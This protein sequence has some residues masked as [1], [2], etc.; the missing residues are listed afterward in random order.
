MQQ[1]QKF[2]PELDAHI[3]SHLGG[4]MSDYMEGK[5]KSSFYDVKVILDDI[6]QSGN[7]NDG[8]DRVDYVINRFVEGLRA[9]KENADNKKPVGD[10]GFF[11]PRR[12]HTDNVKKIISSRIALAIY[13]PDSDSLDDITKSY[14]W[15]QSLIS[16]L[17]RLFK[18]QEFEKI[19]RQEK[20]KISRLAEHRELWESLKTRPL[21]TE[22]TEPT[23]MPVEVSPIE[24]LQPFFNFLSSNKEVLEERAGLEGAEWLTDDK[25]YKFTRGAIYTDGRMDLCKQ[26]VGPPHIESLMTSL[27]HNDKV[28][29]FLLGNNIIGQNGGKAVKTF[30]TSEH[31]PHIRTWYLAGNDLDAVG[32][33]DVVDGLCDDTDV[34]ELWLKRNPIKADGAV[35]IRRLLEKNNTLNTLDLHNTG[36]LDEGF[37]HVCEGLKS[38]RSVKY[39]YFE[40]NGITN[41]DP[42]VSYFEHMIESNECGITS[43]WIGMNR[44]SDD[45][46]I[47]LCNAIKNY[48]WLERLCIGS[49][50]ISHR[51]CQTIY[52]AFKNH[53]TI[54]LLDM[55]LYKSTADMGEI[56]N[57]IGDEGARWI[58]K[59]ISENT[60][61][62]FVSVLHNDISNDGIADILLGLQHNE[63]LL[64][65]ETKQYFVGIEQDVQKKINDI[66]NVN[67][68]RKGITSPRSY[69]RF[70]KH[71]DDIVN[72]DSIYRNNDKAAGPTCSLKKQKWLESKKHA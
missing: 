65:L 8:D 56:T 62:E 11:A 5:R 15:Y 63:N 12:P 41:I 34:K 57:R 53:P 4:I 69:L 16:R 40:A 9:E 43:L 20:F 21:S 19:V 52:D 26:V 72:I 58:S 28:T 47:K 24:E 39:I 2:C 71:T 70:L 13:P 48:K 6:V 67:R 49:N 38:N 3:N 46:A 54:K 64:Y 30:L 17:S 29:H 37:A 55:G 42:I 23:A 36:L 44:L 7:L 25:C 31:T 27:V 68:S 22:V 14:V 50:M 61:L 1:E 35:H 59:L 45:G 32:I 18:T 66:L 10:V 33:S 60:S 51:S